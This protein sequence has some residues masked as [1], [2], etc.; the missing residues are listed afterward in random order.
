[1]ALKGI[2]VCIGICD[3]MSNKT[4][5]NYLLIVE[6]RGKYSVLFVF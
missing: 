1:M 3:N 4:N 2:S 6:D 5:N